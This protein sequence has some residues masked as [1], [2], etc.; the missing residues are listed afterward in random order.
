MKKS[1]YVN[2]TKDIHDSRTKIITITELDIEKL[3]EA[4]PIWLQIQEKIVNDIGKV[5]YGNFFETLKAIQE[6]IEY[7]R[8]KDTENLKL[9]ISL[10]LAS[11]TDVTPMTTC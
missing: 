7:T 9:P 5:S 10:F 4:I 6:S 2:I 3:K 11:L 1:G 8:V